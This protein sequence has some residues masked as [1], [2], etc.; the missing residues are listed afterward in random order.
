MR[1]AHL[2]DR[3]VVA[4]CLL[5]LLT[6]VAARAFDFPTPEP[7]QAAKARPLVWA[8]EDCDRDFDVQF[9]ARA[10][11]GNEEAR[12]RFNSQENGDGYELLLAPAGLRL[13]RVEAGL[14]LG[15]LDLGTVKLNGRPTLFVL[16]RR[17]QAIT[18]VANGTLVARAFDSTFSRGAVGS[19]GDGVVVEDV[20]VQPVEELFYTD[21]FMKPAG[22]LGEW[23]ALSGKW[24]INSLDNP[25][26]SSN[27][28][29]MLGTAA[30]AP[31]L[32]AAGSWFWDNYEYA[33]SVQGTGDGAVGIAFC[34]QDPGNYYVVRWEPLHET[35]SRGKRQLLRVRDGKQTVLAESY[36]GFLPSQWYRLD[37]TVGE[38]FAQVRIDGNLV[39]TA[40][41][42]GL[43][44]GRAGLYTESPTTTFFDDVEVHGHKGF[45]DDFSAPVPGA[46][47]WLGGEWTRADAGAQSGATLLRV[48]T[49]KQALALCEAAVCRNFEC[50]V[51]V[52]LADARRAG[53]CF[54]Y[55]DPLNYYALTVDT[56]TPALTFQRVVEGKLET[57]ATAAL[58]PLRDKPHELRLRCEEGHFTA[59]LDGL[60]L[61]EAWDRELPE[62]KVGLVVERATGVTF[63]NFGL[64]LTDRQTRQ[65]VYTVHEVFSKEKSMEDW[66]A[67]ASDWLSPSAEPTEPGPVVHWHRADFYGDAEIDVLLSELS[68]AGAEI[69]LFASAEDQQTDSGYA[70]ALKRDTGIQAVLLR[71]GQEVARQ[72]LP[73]EAHPAEMSLRRAGRFVVGLVDQ[74]PVLH[75]GDPKP[76]PGIS[77]GYSTARIEVDP[78][79]VKVYADDVYTYTFKEAPTDWR[80]A[81][82]V[83]EITN[84]WECDPRWSFFS[85]REEKALAV[86]WSKRIF[87]GDGTLEFAGATKMNRSKEQHA[88][89]YDYASDINATICADGQDLTSGYSFLLGGWGN[90]YTRLLKGATT[91]AESTE[92]IIP[93]QKTNIH[94][95]WFYQKIQKRGNR[96]RYW[97]DNKLVFDVEDPTPLD[98]NRLGLW[99]YNNGVMIARVRVSTHDGSHSELLD[100]PLSGKATCIYDLPQQQTQ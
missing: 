43:S 94:H 35:G 15:L 23:E 59:A 71:A 41:D 34:V 2:S 27:A 17:Q 50:A 52:G 30:G 79:N 1:S 96:L 60:D 33:A 12:L 38:G 62:G 97:I 67:A 95:L 46:W 65:P 75:F 87:R 58:L 72:S 21:D 11:S 90:K 31:A 13:I 20:R 6:A 28:F 14:Q 84:R 56:A 78:A 64:S 45:T 26:L 7:Y 25:V 69:Q 57:L 47:A 70:F 81:A 98:G 61:L 32:C 93:S 24:A 39:L 63:D 73:A 49:E 22:E 85:G 86:L 42:P 54:R 16:K 100:R 82:G 80:P 40:A 83:W 4:A 99:T 92:D 3:R 44:H 91:L 77:V 88:W 19:A 29:S 18:L 68:E 66:A 9:S 37:A 74:Q 55:Q 36:G 8:E 89:Q 10:T 53:L 76:L 51:N 48:S 5:S